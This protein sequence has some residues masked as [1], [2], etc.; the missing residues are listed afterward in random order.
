[1]VPVAPEASLGQ[2]TIIVDV[3]NVMGARPDGWWKDRAGAALRLCREV[4]ALAR[5]GLPVS[6][7]PPGAALW[8]EAEAPETVHGERLSP[9][10]VLVLE[11]R[12]RQAADFLSVE[13]GSSGSAL[14][15][16]D[17]DRLV[18]LVL[19]VGSGDD[20]IVDVARGLPGFTIVATADRELRQRCEQAG[21]VTAGP[22]W[23]LR[24]L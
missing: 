3:A 14:F 16:A 6:E 4:T 15:L 10:W 22:G 12:A 24:L 11:G 20:A 18:R 5:R 2:I 1:V 7:L 19:A 9:D 23:L 13:A 21:A 8:A 17:P